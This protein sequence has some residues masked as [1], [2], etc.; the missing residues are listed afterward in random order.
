MPLKILFVL[1]GITELSE[2]PD[3]AESWATFCCLGDFD[4]EEK[5]ALTIEIENNE[6]GIIA[7]IVSHDL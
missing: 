5:S 2:Q 6:K 3:M 4:D 7:H 1:L